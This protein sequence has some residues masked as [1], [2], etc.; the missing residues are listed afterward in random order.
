LEITVWLFRF[1]RWRKENDV[2]VVVRSATMDGGSEVG[3][4]GWL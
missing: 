2:K 3:D 4:D 1:V